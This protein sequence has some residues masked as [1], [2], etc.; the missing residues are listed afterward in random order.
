LYVCHVDWG[1]IKQRPHH[2]A[3][4]LQRFFDVTVVFNWNWRRGNLPNKFRVSRLCI[5]LPR[6]PLRD[7]VP[8]IAK[9][10]S[11]VVRMVIQFAMWLVRPTYVWLTWPGMVQYL[12]RRINGCVIYDCMDDALA[13]PGDAHRAVRIEEMERAL[14]ARSLIV[15]VSS[16]RLCRVLG[17]RYGELQKYHLLRNAFDGKLLPESKGSRMGGCAYK[18]G[19]CGTIAEWLDAKLLTKL[20]EAYPN[21]EVHLVGAL[22][23][24]IRVPEHNRI[25]WH[26]PVQHSALPAIMGKFDCLIMPF[27]V[28]PL[29]ESVDPVKLYE[30][31]NFGIPIVSVYYDEIARFA[32]FVHFYRSHEEALDIVSQLAAGELGREYTEEERRAFLLA[33]TWIERASVASKLM[34]ATGSV[35]E[36]AEKPQEQYHS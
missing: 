19:Y 15:F 13:F 4:H 7:R 28:T 8:L 18:I 35:S 2:L 29:I 25:V 20:V 16:E 10:D 23:G 6:L 22:D 1:W 14:V 36:T 9:V 11:L 34:K 32:P 30:Y 26:G 31:I 3:E 21:I 33:N 27:Q 24:E 12:P 17:T 5:P